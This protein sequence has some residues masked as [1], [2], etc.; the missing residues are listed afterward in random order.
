MVAI[1]TSVLVTGFYLVLVAICTRDEQRRKG[2]NEPLWALGTK[3][4]RNTTHAYL[5]WDTPVYHEYIKSGWVMVGVTHSRTG[6]KERIYAHLV[7]PQKEG[8][9]GGA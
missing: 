7:L 5:E 9:D 1:G 8:N 2:M 4:A 3:G 6:W